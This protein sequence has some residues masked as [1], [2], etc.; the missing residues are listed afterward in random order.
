M[1]VAA[2]AAVLEKVAFE[3]NIL[4]QSN[5]SALTPAGRDTLNG[6][7][8]KITGLESRSVTAVGYA[9]RMGSEASNQVLSEERVNVV[10]ATVPNPD[11][12]QKAISGGVPAPVVEA[13]LGVWPGL[14]GGLF[15]VDVLA[16]ALELAW[17]GAHG[18][19][20]QV[21]GEHAV[22]VDPRQSDLVV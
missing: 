22:A 10:K 19:V 15:T 6:F 1:V 21:A 13:G 9:D 8:G 3:A 2:A 20:A 12:T 11:T 17:F 18:L 16:S 5:K 14:S 7:V 4:F